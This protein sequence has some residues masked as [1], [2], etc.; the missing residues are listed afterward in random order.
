MIAA[1]GKR[2]AVHMDGRL[3]RLS[4]AIGES[5]VDVV[6]AFTPAPMGDLSVAEARAAWPAKALWLN[7]TSSMHVEP[8]DRIAAH[9]RQLI[10]EAGTRRGFAIG[11]TENIPAEHLARSLSV[12]AR[13]IRDVG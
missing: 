6:E 3:R 12:I 13:T 9:T 10:E 5:P 11:V 8:A 4:E 2:L 1:S 7:F